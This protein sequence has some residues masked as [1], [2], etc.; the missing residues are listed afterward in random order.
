MG[1]DAG[2]RSDIGTEVRR[3]GRRRSLYGSQRLF[4]SLIVLSLFLSSFLY[5]AVMVDDSDPAEPER[6]ARILDNSAPYFVFATSP[7][8][9]TNGD[10]N[11]SILFTTYVKDNNSDPINITW[12]WGDGK[13]SYNQ[14]GPAGSVTKVITN[15]T[16]AP[17]IPPGQ[18]YIEFLLNITLNDGNG[19]T[20]LRVIT[21][22]ITLPEANG[23]PA[24]V[25]LAVTG[26]TATKIDPS[27]EV[28]ISACGNDTEGEALIWTFVFNDSVQDY[29]TV[30]VQTEETT[31][32]EL[33]WC[34]ITHTFGTEGSHSV[35][36]YLTD[37][38][39]PDYQIFPHNVSLTRTYEVLTNRIPYVADVINVNP[40]TPIID[41][42]DTTYVIVNFS[43]EAFDQDGD[44]ITATWDFGDGSPQEVNT[45]AGGTRM[46]EFIQFRNY[47]LAGL[48]NVSVVITDGRTGHEVFRNVKV[49]VNSTNLPPEVEKFRA[50][51][52]S[53]GI[54]ALVNETVEFELIIHDQESDPIEVTIDWGDGSPLL[55]FNLTEFVNSN[56]TIYMNHTYVA[57]GNYT[58]IVYYTDNRIGLYDHSVNYSLRIQI[59]EIFEAVPEYWSWWDYTS[60]GLVCMIPVLVA[61]RFFMVV[62][63]RKRVEAEGFSLEEWKLLKEQRKGGEI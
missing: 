12:E 25:S 35:T 3:R 54:Y 18:D 15:H 21:V 28:T 24:I 2:L 7:K 17:P 23:P 29:R 60:L 4:M 46:Y 13:V 51:N 32:D 19:S 56:A 44:I 50:L 33:V 37:A 36:V 53:G 52:L 5:I 20:A 45:S 61:L 59:W 27:D 10:Y 62:R 47:T 38:L 55:H 42:P 58:I 16:Y 43:I 30:V 6:R 11:V 22:H 57:I 31:P 49:M 8:N 34:N 39:V 40:G 41:F 9:P 14:T 1:A 48:Q 26:T 63:Q